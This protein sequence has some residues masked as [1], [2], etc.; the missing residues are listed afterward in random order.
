M[1]QMTRD[2]AEKNFVQKDFHD[3]CVDLSKFDS[4]MYNVEKWPNILPR[5]C[6]DHTAKTFKACLAIFN[7][8]HEKVNRQKILQNRTYQK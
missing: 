6:S 5:S 7:I 2:L 1:L 3:V 4:F 8:I